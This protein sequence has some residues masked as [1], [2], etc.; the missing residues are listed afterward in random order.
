[1]PAHHLHLLIRETFV[2]SSLVAV[3]LKSCGES[4]RR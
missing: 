2:E 1:M 3:Y 4:L